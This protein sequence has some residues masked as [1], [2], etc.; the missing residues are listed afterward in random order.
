MAKSKKE[1][2]EER[3]RRYLEAFHNEMT[4][5][6]QVEATAAALM[7]LAKLMAK[8]EAEAAQETEDVEQAQIDQTARYLLKDVDI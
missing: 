1:T 8:K 5:R 4:P 7:L 2:T 6:E 3:K